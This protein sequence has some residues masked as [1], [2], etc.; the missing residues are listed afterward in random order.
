MIERSYGRFLETSG[1]D[2]LQALSADA[3]AVRAGIRQA[4]A[5]GFRAVPGKRRRKPSTFAPGLTVGAEKAA[6]NKV[7]PTGLEPVLPT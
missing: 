4:A 6:K 3:D 1:F 7:V 2:P 5:Q